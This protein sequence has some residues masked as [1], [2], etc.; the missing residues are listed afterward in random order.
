MKKYAY[1]FEIMPTSTTSNYVDMFELI[2]KLNKDGEEGW[3]VVSILHDQRRII[4]KREIQ[5]P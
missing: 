4:Y 3:E 5:Q 1:K 2:K